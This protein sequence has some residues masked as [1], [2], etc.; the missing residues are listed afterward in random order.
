MFEPKFTF[1]PKIVN[2]L[3]AIERLYGSLLEQELIP[4]LA[5]A[6]AQENQVLA[7]HHSTSI[8][9]NPLSPRDV[10]NIV[11]GDAVPTT[12]SEKEIKNYFAVLVK[13]NVL[14]KKHEPQI[15]RA[16]V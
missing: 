7:T 12:K 10:T 6:L 13:I 15:G 9:G 5:L 14:S 8:E 3:A 16:H 1:T 4:S 2:T 11:L